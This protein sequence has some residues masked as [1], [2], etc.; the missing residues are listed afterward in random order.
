LFRVDVVGW[1]ARKRND[2]PRGV[3]EVSDG[4]STVATTG[5]RV[6]AFTETPTP[7]AAKAI[8]SVTSIMAHAGY[9]V[10]ANALAR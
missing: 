10:V 5:L 6:S 9:R 8:V 4:G 3:G 7:A 1:Q 2:L